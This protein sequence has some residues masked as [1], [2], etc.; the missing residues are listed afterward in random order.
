MVADNKLR[1]VDLLIWD[2]GLRISDL[3]NSIGSIKKETPEPNPRI[4]TS[5]IIGSIYSIQ[6]PKCQIR[7]RKT[8]NANP[9]TESYSIKNIL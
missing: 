9:V 2:L 3:R 5:D 6:N 8:R 4:R 1:G 7:N